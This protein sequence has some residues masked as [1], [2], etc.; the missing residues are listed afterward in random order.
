[1]NN[2]PTLS[3][4]DTQILHL[5]QVAGIPPGLE[6]PPVPPNPPDTISP[7]WTKQGGARGPIAGL[8][9]IGLGLGLLVAILH[10][11]ST[12]TRYVA[13]LPT[14]PVNAV[15]ATLTLIPPTVTATGTSAPPATA[16]AIPSA[17]PTV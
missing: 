5:L 3:L 13:A 2:N 17:T 7:P 8:L 10:P 12:P 6:R 1:M 16:T 4:S 14:N 15:P 11:D 9:G